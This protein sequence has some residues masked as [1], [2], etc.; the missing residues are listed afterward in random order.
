MKNYA[1]LDGKIM[2]AQPKTPLCDEGFL[3]GQGLFET[4]RVYGGKAFLLQRHLQR[5]IDSCPIMDIVR[6]SRE[7]LA[8][9]VTETIKKNK[10]DSGCVRLNIWKRGKGLGIFA[11]ARNVEL[12]S[13]ADYNKGFSAIIVKD[14]RQ[15]ELSPLPRVKSLNHSFYIILSK[16]A[17]KEGVDE[18]LFLNSKGNICEGSR[19]NIFIVRG[20]TLVAP[21]VTAGCLPGITRQM[22][23]EIAQQL[24]INLLEADI[25]PDDVTCSSQAFLTNSLVE[26]MPLTMVEGRPVGSGKPGTLTLTILQKYRSRIQSN[27]E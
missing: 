17:E 21:P 22:V 26:I 27:C 10:L 15:N 12:C 24:Q 3:Y 6:P 13:N 5:M 14:I 9:A 18:S 2:V 25:A 7:A 11:F 4:M 8:S 20:N 19:S 1:W 16:R 23:F